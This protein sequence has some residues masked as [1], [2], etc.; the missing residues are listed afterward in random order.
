MFYS[1]LENLYMNIMCLYYA[2][3]LVELGFKMSLI[4]LV[5]ICIFKPY[6]LMLNL[7]CIIFKLFLKLYV[8]MH[9]N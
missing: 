5:A 7:S 3:I 4:Y 9:H 6:R 2:Y 8:N 1:L